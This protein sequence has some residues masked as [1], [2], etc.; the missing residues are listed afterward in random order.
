M[1]SYAWN[2]TQDQV[3]DMILR[4]LG[5]LGAADVADADDAAVV[6]EAMNARLKEMHTI[7]VL[8][9][10]VAAAQT[11]L[12]LT[13][14]A[15]TATVAEDDFLYPLTAS[16]DINTEQKSLE[17]IGHGQYQAIADKARIGEPEQVFFSG[18]VARFWP[19]PSSAYTARLTYQAI[20]AD[21][22]TN[23][24]VDIPAAAVRPFVD[25]VAG[26]LVDDF[27]IDAA[28][29]ARLIAKQTQAMK[30]IRMVAYQRVDS[31]PVTPD[32]Y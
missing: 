31:A 19:V 23:T 22:E 16:L 32:Y 28:R 24:P 21:I 3:R 13:A 1:A 12:T 9:W 7:G 14:N 29:A 30:A 27:G 15:A 26:D 25:L 6:V 18:S 8:W 20:S 11:A 10:N 5:V 4:K 17:I 2:R